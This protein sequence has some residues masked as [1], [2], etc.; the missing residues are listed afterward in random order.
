MIDSDGHV[1]EHLG[2][3]I[4]TVSSQISK[5]VTE[6]LKELW[7]VSN[8]KIRDAPCNSFSNKPRFEIYIPSAEIKLHKNKIPS[9]KI[10]R[11]LT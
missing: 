6:I 11:Y 1:H 7:I 2:T 8:T 10:A 5:R 9:V 3:E 4:K